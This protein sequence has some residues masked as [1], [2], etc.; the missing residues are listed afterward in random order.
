LSERLGRAAARRGFDMLER[1]LAALAPAWPAPALRTA[2]GCGWLRNRLSGAWPS[3]EQVRF[4]FPG[5]ERGAAARIA[6]RIGGMEGRNRLLVELIRRDGLSTVR[7]LVRTPAMLAALRPPLV[8]CTFHVG[9]MQ[10]LGAALER[11]PAPVLAL[12][13]GLLGTAR[14]PLEIVSTHGHDEG[15]AAAFHRCLDRLQRGGFAAMAIDL[16]AGPG[17]A[18]PCL[19]RWLTLARGPFALARLAGAPLV[20]IV[21]R[22]RSGEIEIV[23]G[24]PFAAEPSSSGGAGA[25]A[26]ENALA[27]AAAGWLERYLVAS[28]GEL[29]LGLLRA[30]LAAGAAPDSADERLEQ[31]PA[32]VEPA[33]VE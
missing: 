12:R 5:L 9:A 22:W 16:T 24:E 32:A 10:G 17:P 25:M 1:Q 20:P 26:R 23:L 6:W 31:R 15:R 27:V 7:P 33:A 29:G 4:V 30:L 8:L 14:P 21:A 11:L 18:A 13:E 2:G 19:G 28:P 3:A